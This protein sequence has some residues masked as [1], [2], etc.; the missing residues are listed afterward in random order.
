MLQLHVRT[1]LSWTIQFSANTVSMSKNSSIWNNSALHKHAVQ[2]VSTVQLSKTFLFQDIQFSI[3][4][5]LVLFNPLIR[6]YQV[7]PSR[8]RVDRGAMAIKV[9]C[10][11]SSIFRESTEL[12]W[13]QSFPFPR[14]G[15]LQMLENPICPDMYS[16][17]GG[18][19]A[20]GLIPFQGALTASSWIWIRIDASI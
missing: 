9:Q 3:S 18:K 11:T 15:R 17:L 16:L 1:V 5:P 6:P 4:I 12:V 19:K 13:V 7:L 20:G 2:N 10:N 14:A 8:A